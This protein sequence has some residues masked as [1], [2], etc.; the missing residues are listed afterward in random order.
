MSTIVTVSVG[1]GTCDFCKAVNETVISADYPDSM[2]ICRPCVTTTCGEAVAVHF[3][4]EQHDGVVL[5]DRT[6]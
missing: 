3:F 1:Y 6:S 5:P 4:D 2:R